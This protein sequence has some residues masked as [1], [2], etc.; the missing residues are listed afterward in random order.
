VP[1]AANPNAPVTCVAVPNPSCAT[2]GQAASR[3]GLLA[4]NAVRPGKHWPLGRDTAAISNLRRSQR[5][6]SSRAKARKSRPLKPMQ[7]PAR[8]R[9]PRLTRAR[10]SETFH[11][12][13]RAPECLP[14]LPSH[15]HSDEVVTRSLASQ[16]TRRRSNLAK[17]QGDT[18]LPTAAQT[19]SQRRQ[20]QTPSVAGYGTGFALL[21]PVVST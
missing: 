4:A 12:L 7:M 9:P 5:G 8:L 19:D 21:K 18:A 3:L 6:E 11:M 13:A 20:R 1:P 17:L 2:E 15:H 16:A 10:V 14:P